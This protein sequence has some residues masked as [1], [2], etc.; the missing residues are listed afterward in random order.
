MHRFILT[1]NLRQG[2]IGKALSSLIPYSLARHPY[3][4]SRHVR[5]GF[6]GVFY[7]P[8]RLVHWYNPK[9]VNVGIMNRQ[10][11]VNNIGSGDLMAGYG[12]RHN[13]GS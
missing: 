9:T 10:N 11:A 2:L 4:F 1:K 3:R 7:R 8:S 12:L 5:S 6:Y 13:L